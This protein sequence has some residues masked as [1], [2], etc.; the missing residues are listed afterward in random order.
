[1]IILQPE[2]LGARISMR[3]VVQMGDR[4]VAVAIAGQICRLLQSPSQDRFAGRR[5][6]HRRTDLPVVVVAIAR[7]VCPSRGVGNLSPVLDSSGHANSEI[8]GAV[9]SA[10]NALLRR[11][12][13]DMQDQAIAVISQVMPV[14]MAVTRTIMSIA[15]LRTKREMVLRCIAVCDRKARRRRDH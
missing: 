2:S 13:G 15:T 6:R 1:M 5:S 8:R 10:G 14:R 7:Q 12:S 4:V 3:S 11:R 9:A